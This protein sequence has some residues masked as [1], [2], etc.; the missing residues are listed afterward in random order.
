VTRRVWGLVVSEADPRRW[1]REQALGT[2]PGI[3]SDRRPVQYTAD[4]VD[5]RVYAAE[6]LLRLR[7]AEP[8]WDGCEP[9]FIDAEHAQVYVDLALSRVSDRWCREPVTVTRRVHRPSAHYRGA[10]YLPTHDRRWMRG[11]IVLHELTHHLT[12]TQRDHHGQAFVD[13]FAEVLT[14]MYDSQAAATF[15]GYLDGDHS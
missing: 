10:I 9:W 5:A 7:L 4:P 1:A 15:L 13:A 2:S 8:P 3:V 6:R 14:V 12:Q 11:L